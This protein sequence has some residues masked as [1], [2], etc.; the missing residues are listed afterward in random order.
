MLQLLFI[1]VV[2]MAVL[3]G[4]TV[5]AATPVVRIEIHSD[6]ILAGD[7][8]TA[9]P[10]LRQADG[11]AVLGYA[12]LPG[13][14]RRVSRAELLRWGEDLGLTL[15]P[16]SLPEAVIL[17]RK[18]RRLE[19][20]QVRGLV[21]E[22]VAGRYGVNASQVEVELHSFAEPLLPDEELDFELVSPLKRLGRPT[23]LSLRWTNPQGRNGSL[24]FRATARVR[25]TYAVARQPIPARTELSAG[26]FTFQQGFLPGDPAQYAMDTPDVEARQLKQSLKAGEALERRMLEAAVTVQ[27]G[28]LIELRLRSPA[29]VLRAAGRAEQSGASGEVIRCRNLQSGATV[30][31]RIVDSRQVEVISFP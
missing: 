8:A 22:A 17:A 7:L 19:A 21:V 9:I 5:S 13:I 4:Q 15:D 6:R 3:P 26:D 27:R 23:T 24:S 12:P 25:G 10:Q 29:V 11:G 14:E 28:D 18:M 16:G 1:A 2:S 20:S 30:Q 31:A